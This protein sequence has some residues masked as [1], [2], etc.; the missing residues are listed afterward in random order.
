MTIKLAQAVGLLNLAGDTLLEQQ[1]TI[2]SL[3]TKLAAYEK[4][5]RV[6]KIAQEMETKGLNEDLTF[7]QKVAALG[8]A[9]NL[10]VQEAAVKMAAPQGNILGDASEVPGN[11][12]MHPFVAFIA[13]VD[14]DD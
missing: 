5:E 9:E 3:E 4:T 11:G 2:E 8:S 14:D 6:T 13:G 12:G 10:S 7:E 1:S